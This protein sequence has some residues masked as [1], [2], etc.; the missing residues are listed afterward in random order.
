MKKRGHSKALTLI[1][2]QV[3]RRTGHTIKY[4]KY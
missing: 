3:N 4:Y 1:S 2:G